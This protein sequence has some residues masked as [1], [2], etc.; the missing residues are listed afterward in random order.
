M[1]SITRADHLKKHMV[2][3]MNNTIPLNQM[4]NSL[5]AAV[6]ADDENSYSN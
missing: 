1:L 6:V 5:L 2:S 3:H 4:G